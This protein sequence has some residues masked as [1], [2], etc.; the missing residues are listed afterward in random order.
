MVIS[1]IKGS[2]RATI[3]DTKLKQSIN[4]MDVILINKKN[5]EGAS[6]FHIVHRCNIT[7]LRSSIIVA[8]H[9][10]VHYRDGIVIGEDMYPLKRS[11]KSFKDYTNIPIDHFIA[12]ERVRI[13]N[14][15]YFFSSLIKVRIRSKSFLICS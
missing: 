5:E 12:H 13:K 1:T 15:I 11:F 6:F 4:M 7:I 9:R 10:L 14:S 8:T 2:I 3:T